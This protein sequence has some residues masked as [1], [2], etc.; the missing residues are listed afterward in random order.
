MDEFTRLKRQ[1]GK[2][3]SDIRNMIAERDDLLSQ[4]LPQE[5]T[6]LL[7]NPGT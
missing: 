5:P 7:C 6:V 3:L 2:Q 4:A 1:L